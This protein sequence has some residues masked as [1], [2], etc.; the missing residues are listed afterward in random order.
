M[1]NDKDFKVKNGI[2]P[3]VY[4]EGLGT[5]ATGSV[6]VGYDLS[7]AAYD[8]KEFD[9]SNEVGASL[10]SYNQFI[11]PDG[12][13]VYVC[14]YSGK[15]VFQ[16][17]LST[18]WDISTAT[19]DSKFGNT[20][21]QTTTALISASFKS[22]GTKMYALDYSGFGRGLYQYTLSTAW[23]VS[24]ISYD[25]VVFTDAAVTNTD[26]G[27]VFFKPDGTKFYIQSY[28]LDTITEYNCSTPWDISTGSASGNSYNYSSD[29]S[30]SYSFSI[31]NDGKFLFIAA[32]ASTVYKYSLTTPW[33]IS[34]ATAVSTFSTL[35]QIAVNTCAGLTFKPDGTKMYVGRVDNSGY[36][37]RVYQYTTG[38]TLA[39]NTLDLST[40]NAFQITPTS[41]IQ[42]GLSNPAASGTVSQA[43]LLLDGA[44]NGYDLSGAAYD[45]VS[46]SVNSQN[47]N[48]LDIAFNTDGTKMY[49]MGNIN[50]TVLQYSLSTGFDLSTASYDNVNFATTSQDTNPRKLSF[51]NDG[52]KMYMFGT[53][54]DTVY[55]YSLSTAFDLST[56]SYDSVSFNASSQS[57]NPYGLAFNSDGTKMYLGGGTVFYQYS[58]S[59]AFD[60]ST[61]SYDSVSFS[62]SGQDN[63]APNLTFN[64]DGTKMFVVTSSNDSV[65]QYSLSTAFDLSTA[66][67][68]SVSFSVG[69]QDGAPNSVA[70]SNDGTKM[71]I[72]GNVN[73]TIFQYST[74]SAY[75]V[76]YDS[77]IQFGGGTA[78]DSPLANETDVLTFS[79][80]DGGTT[81]QAAQA[82][83]GAV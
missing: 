74:G 1:S 67:Y 18:A 14:S 58:L 65:Y 43:T 46:F 57:T 76:T 2:Q 78:P 26:K 12:T 3:A 77:T 19:Y 4:Q 59:T 31:S 66:S 39:T 35:G 51:N 82:I 56:T 33:D 45:S 27:N 55:Q 41:N 83:D 81:Y 48:P 49:I 22:D 62:V 7:V 79:T 24:T 60:L 80:R 63:D 5:I 23:D 50:D 17:S 52:T 73:D 75:T 42:V 25:S 37:D 34:T 30:T 10:A 61:T 20:A 53:T 44:A 11:K 21:T 6:V 70:F 69:S 8:T 28:S 15:K 71:Y 68:D 47:T 38:S 13:K 36:S 29:I 64:N 72:V 40:G 32:L 9:F 16:Y 54:T